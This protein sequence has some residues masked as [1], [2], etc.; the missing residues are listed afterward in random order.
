MQR[1]IQSCCVLVELE[2]AE[3]RLGRESFPAVNNWPAHTH[4]HITHTYTHTNTIV[5][6][7]GY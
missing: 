2:S 7:L 5:M 4:T 3:L 1:W 6:H